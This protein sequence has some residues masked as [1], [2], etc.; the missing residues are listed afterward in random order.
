MV[1][2]LGV[3]SEGGVTERGQAAPAAEGLG[4]ALCHSTQVHVVIQYFELCLNLQAS[5][6]LGHA[7]H[8]MLELRN[9]YQK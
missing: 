4:Q 7:S 2:L 3:R 8:V 5:K 9:I 1:R 6:E